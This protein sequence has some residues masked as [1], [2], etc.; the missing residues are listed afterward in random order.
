MALIS[1]LVKLYWR[2][3]HYCCYAQSLTLLAVRYWL[4]KSFFFSGLLKTKSWQTTLYLFENEY[5]VPLLPPQVAAYL[6]TAAEIFLPVLVLLGILTRLSASAFLIFNAII[7]ISYP[8]LWTQ[9][10]KMGLQQHLLWGILML[11]LIS[12]GPGKISVDNFILRKSPN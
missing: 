7:L 8:F 6:G 12:F 1:R 5:S 9:D 10:G 11:V 3:V 2:Y 4:F